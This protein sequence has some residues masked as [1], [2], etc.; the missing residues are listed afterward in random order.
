MFW[1]IYL[2]LKL[3]WGLQIME[4]NILYIYIYIYIL[5]FFLQEKKSHRLLKWLIFFSQ[6]LSYCFC[7]K[8]NL[9]LQC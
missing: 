1:N 7:N 8:E 9:R 5:H 6:Q 4:S 3:L 2:N